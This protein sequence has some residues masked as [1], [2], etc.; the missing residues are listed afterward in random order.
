[1]ANELQSLSQLFN[2]RLFRI[3]DYQRGY[4]WLQ[5][6]LVDFWD[7]L[8]NLQ[9]DRY[10]YTGLLSLKPLKSDELA[11]W[12][13]DLWLVKNGYKPCHIV[14]GQQRITTFLI[15]LNEIVGFVRGLDKNRDNSDKEI[16]LGYETVEEIVSKYICRKRSQNSVVTTYFFGYEVDNPSAE[17]MKYKVF[18]E[19]YSGTISE[20]YYTKNLEFAKEFFARNIRRLYDEFREVGLEA[21]TALYKK[22]TQNLMFNLHEISDDYNVL[23][24]FETMNNRGK[25]LTNLEL[26]KNRLI[27]LTTLYDSDVFDEIEKSSLRKKINDAWKEVYYQLGRNKTIPLSD[28]DFLRA[29]WIIYFSYSRKRG[30]DYINFLLN[31]FSPKCIFEKR[32]VLVESEV[33]PAI[34]DDIADAEDSEVA[35]MEEMETMEVSKLQPQDIENYINSL[36]D[37]AKYWYDTFFPSESANLTTDEKKYV[38]SLNRIGIGYFRP[39]VAVVISRRD[40]LPES[41]VKIFKAIERFIFISFRLGNFN[42][43]YKSS[44][45]YRTTRLFYSKEKDIDELCNEIDNGIIKYLEEAKNNFVIR[46]GKCFS[47]GKGSG[48]YNWSSLRYFFYEYETWLAEKNNI[49]RFCTWSMFTKSEKDK[50]SIE[51]ILPQTLTDYWRNMFRQFSDSEIKMLSG[52]IG[53]LL[54]LSKSI[55]SA[56][57]NDSFEDKKHSKTSGRRGYENGSHSE[58]EVSKLQDWTASEIYNRSERLLKFMQKRWNFEFT[59]EQ[60]TK[61]IGLSFVKNNSAISENK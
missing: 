28:D 16:I 41:R 7:D 55:N 4:A 48:Y 44:D 54:P 10:H 61:L 2:Q 20:S 11:S 13:E 50:V 17:Y 53:N 51:H 43:S 12:G 32:P 56:L 42:A 35:E 1:M 57:Q 24:A 5:Q 8:V 46:I 3:P 31:K 18:G 36:K 21:V 47:V 33:E 30:D 14:D 38:D 49:D 58:I 25:K 29:H 15:L 37:M 26:L 52:A 45:F 27:Y 39:L 34:I 9:D 40:I 59:E 60:M 22:L 23:V 19:P 6:Q